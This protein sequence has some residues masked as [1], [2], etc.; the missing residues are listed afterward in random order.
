MNKKT[1]FAVLLTCGMLCVSSVSAAGPVMEFNGEAIGK[2]APPIIAQVNALVPMRAIFEKS[3]MEVKWN[4]A[5]QTAT[6]QST[7]NS[8]EVTIGATDGKVNSQAVKLDTA[9]SIQNNRTMVPISLVK[10]VLGCKTYI[11]SDNNTVSVYTADFLSRLDQMKLSFMLA[12]CTSNNVKTAQGNIQMSISVIT[13]RKMD[14]TLKYDYN[15]VNDIDFA[16]VQKVLSDSSQ[17]DAQKQELIN[18]LKAYLTAQAAFMEDVT[19][20]KSKLEGTLV[21]SGSDNK[22]KRY[23]SWSNYDYATGTIDGK[24]FRWTPQFDDKI[25]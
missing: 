19:G 10:Q 9:P 2:D 3:G 12:R 14:A 24:G 18:T 20:G 13:Q 16:K 8:V 25:D 7:T 11:N 22:T 5:T 1:I 17:T 6:V 23:L 4:Q 15:I 21:Y